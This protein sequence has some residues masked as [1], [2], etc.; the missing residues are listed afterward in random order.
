[1][2]EVELVV[3]VVEDAGVLVRA[4]GERDLLGL[5]VALLLEHNALRLLLIVESVLAEE[6]ILLVLP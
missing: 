6:E 3:V 5:L 1:M 2:V 4:G